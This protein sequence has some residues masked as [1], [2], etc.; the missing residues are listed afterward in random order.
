MKKT[1]APTLFLSLILLISLAIPCIFALPTYASE[2]DGSESGDANGTD[3][4]MHVDKTAVRNDDG[5]YTITLEAYAKGSKVITETN[6]SIPA[7]IVLVLDQ[8]GSMNDMMSY[9][10]TPYTN[11]TNEA[12]YQLRHN[13]DGAQNLYYPLG[14]RGYVPVAVDKS[15]A[16]TYSS[17][18]YY[19]SNSIYSSNWN[20][21]YRWTGYE[22]LKVTL[23][24]WS[25][26]YG[27]HYYYST[28]DGWWF[29][30]SGPGTSPEDFGGWGPLYR[31]NENYKYLYRYPNQ[32]GVYELLAE[33]YGSTTNP[34]LNLYESIATSS[35]QRLEALKTA[36]DAFIKSVEEKAKG[37]DGLY[38]TDDDVKHRIAIVGFA[39]GDTELYDDK[40]TNTEVF[41]GANEYNYNDNASD[42]YA[43][44]LQNMYTQTGYENVL[45]SK[46]ALSASGATYPNYGLEMAKGI[47]DAN[48]ILSG[49]K[50]NRIV[51][52]FTDGAP[53]YTGSFE[54][55]VADATVSVADELK[56]Q[57]TG[58]GATIYTVGIFDGADATAS[59]IETGSINRLANHFMHEVS[60]N[61][62]AVLDPSYYLSTSDSDKLKT[63]FKEISNQIETGG[64]S[65][66]LD[67]NAVIKDVISPFFELPEDATDDAISLKTYAYGKDATGDT[68]TE[69]QTALGATASIDENKVSVSGFDYSEHWCG[70][71]T[72]NGQE[73]YRGNKL[74]I[75]FTVL[76]KPGFLGGNDVPT[77]V[78]AGLFENASASTALFDF[79][80][81][82]VNVPIKKVTV[83]TPD[84]HI[85]ILQHI[86]AE[87]LRSSSVKV[88]NVSL[89][90]NKMNQNYGL[91]LW[92]NAHVNINFTI[93]DKDDT[94]ISN[95]FSQLTDDNTYT[96]TVSVS[97]KISL[98]SN[99]AAS[100]QTGKRTGDVYVY[101]PELTFKD[102]TA[103]YGDKSDNYKSE[104]L[105]NNL[106]K[107]R[108]LHEEK[109]PADATLMG[110][111]P[112]LRMAFTADEN[113]FNQLKTHVDTK[114]D[115][116]VYVRVGIK[117]DGFNEALEITEHTSFL[118]TQCDDTCILPENS[119]ARFLLHVKTAQLTVSKKGGADGE[120]YV[121]TVYKDGNKYSEVTLI[122]NTSET[123]FELPL[124]NYSISED[125]NWSW[126][127]Q[128]GESGVVSLSS[129][130]PSAEITCTNEKQKSF[131]LNGYSTVI[132]NIFGVQN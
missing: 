1:K 19:Y 77:N 50:R 116:P 109:E 51:V 57:Q 100:E 72:T 17:Y 99:D 84:Y 79:P 123:L 86:S 66:T 80:K 95:N 4:G 104:I 74:V 83:E 127:Y 21:L 130:I 8:S 20:N 88:G 128:A 25:D 117:P 78:H 2:A 125:E 30:S 129:K 81:P 87:T 61:N 102:D 119:N 36:A 15:P 55:P 122:G 7:D 71:V 34:R 11:K 76:P 13:G 48:P 53:G 27:Y 124:G 82:K 113:Y 9:D 49:E 106:T 63:I 37:P 28:S 6:E 10:F 110:N 60:S 132:K 92:Q 70:T 62:G 32:D 39:T 54:D 3:S 103:W 115:I 16:H 59:G 29:Y 56:D 14:D 5:T 98:N 105:R 89:D 46:N 94:N 65:S 114:E 126:R 108:W 93:T 23:Q 44:A 112:S 111:A 18:S 38:E 85:Y 68:W 31:K 43:E 101:K 96:I 120:P 22:Y 42:H 52:L 24:V 64:S 40:F 45:A 67:E 107:T 73:T 58:A 75:S 33:S 47:F 118:H 90:L 131:W 12:L 35:T 26:N 69:N 121:F 91:D 97:P 41:V